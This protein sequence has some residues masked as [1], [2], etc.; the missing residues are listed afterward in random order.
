MQSS[1]EQT[2]SSHSPFRVLHPQEAERYYDHAL[3]EI[4][5]PL[6]HVLQLSWTMRWDLP[7]DVAFGARVVPSAYANLTCMPEGARVTGVTTG[8]YDYQIRGSG[9]IVGVMFRPGGIAAFFDSPRDLVDTHL[10]AQ[11]LF[12]AVDEEF[13]NEVIASSDGAALKRIHEQLLA[14][15]P[16]PDPNIS[17]IN[18]I[19]ERSQTAKE[20]T[21]R[22]IAKEFAMSE[23]KLQSLFERYVGVGL[24]WIMLRDRLQRATLP[25]DTLAAPNWTEIAHEL[26]YGDQSHFIHDFKR[27]VGMTPRQY[28]LANHRRTYL[29]AQS[30]NGF[31]GR[32]STQNTGTLTVRAEPEKRS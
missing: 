15:L 31:P 6:S 25:A 29:G 16:A 18:E 4:E 14:H 8:L 5:G 2:T 32:D 12:P 30:Q 9:V 22:S 21:V 7:A 26:G 24:K 19:I 23:R 11:R 20:S 17:L 10:P 3:Y 13:N 27:I 28:A 1:G